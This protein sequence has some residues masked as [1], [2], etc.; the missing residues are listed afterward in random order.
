MVTWCKE[1]H[2]GRPAQG[3]KSMSQNR[4]SSPSLG[5][6]QP[7]GRRQIEL[8]EA[9]KHQTERRW[10]QVRVDL[11]SLLSITLPRLR[12]QKL[13]GPQLGVVIDSQKS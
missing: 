7:E 4:V 9:N 8:S 3:G 2:V 10:E 6:V 11:G 13:Q 12:D 5:V 1:G